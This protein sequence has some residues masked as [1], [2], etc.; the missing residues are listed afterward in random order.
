[1]GEPTL[2]H[3]EARFRS[4][5]ADSHISAIFRHSG[6]AISTIL[7]S[8]E[9]AGPNRAQILGT[10][11]RIEIEGVWYAPT[12]FRVIAKNKDVIE[13]YRSDVSGGGKQ[14]EADELE[15]M[16][17]NG[18]ISSDIMPLTETVAIM[19]TLDAVRASIG[20]RYPWE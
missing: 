10:K 9:V 1:M 12:S 18:K 15:N 5:G 16:V 14:F 3:A 7:A 6:G 4:T 13:E 11:A 20:L 8:S 2:T 17:A 19:K